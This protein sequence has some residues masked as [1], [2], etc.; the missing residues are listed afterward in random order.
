MKMI[1]AKKNETVQIQ[2]M[3][4]IGMLQ[5]FENIDETTDHCFSSISGQ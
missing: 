1:I 4:N 5:E 3:M 2:A